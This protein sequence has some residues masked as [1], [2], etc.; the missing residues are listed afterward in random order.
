MMLLGMAVEPVLPQGGT[1]RE[2]SKTSSPTKTKSPTR[3]TKP[4]R[5]ST[6]L[7]ERKPDVARQ[8]PCVA[9]PPTSRTGH[10]YSEDLNGVKLEMVEIPA[11]SFCMG[12]SPPYEKEFFKGE[13]P[14]KDEGPQH[15]VTMQSF[16]IGKYEV[17]QAQYQAVMGVNPS[18]F[19]GRNLP[20]ETV[21]WNDAKEFCRRLSQMAGREYRLPTEAEWEYACRAGTTTAFAFGDSLSADQANFD[22]RYP[23]GGAA[24]GDFRRQTTPVGSFQPNAYGL[25]DMHGNVSEWCEDWKHDSYNG[26][27]TDG[28]AWLSGGEQKSRVLRGGDWGSFA[29]HLRSAAREGNKPDAHPWFF[30]LRVVATARS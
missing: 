9:H 22:G 13:L 30:G 2:A 28:S 6:P 20:V 21:S 7:S 14:Y 4:P 18:K 16:Y 24:K 15:R 29:R 17:T 25:Y 26:A 19:K 10:K 1:G 23:F 3:V 12:S 27:P 8:A 11:A 5:K